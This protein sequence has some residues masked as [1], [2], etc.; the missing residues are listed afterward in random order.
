M[1]HQRPGTR[2]IRA[3]SG[4]ASAGRATASGA[5]TGGVR[6]GAPALLHDPVRGKAVVRHQ[7]ECCIARK[8]SSADGWL[9]RERGVW[10]A[11][12]CTGTERTAVCVCVR[13]RHADLFLCPSPLESLIHSALPHSAP[14]PLIR[15]TPSSSCSP[16]APPSF[17]SDSNIFTNPH[18]DVIRTASLSFCSFMSVWEM[19]SQVGG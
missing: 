19:S 3:H 9:A 18:D 5:Y 11:W 1:Q 4:G 7:V 17:C 15:T 10:T 13:E 2:L 6:N 8:T 14:D 12:A 16:L